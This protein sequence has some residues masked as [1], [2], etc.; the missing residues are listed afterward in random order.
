[1]SIN[2]DLLLCALGLAFFMEGMFYSLFSKKLPDFFKRMSGES[3]VAFRKFGI[4]A[5]LAGLLL[6]GT[7]RI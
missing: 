3:P 4:I 6:I 5:M 1:M 2:L 7:T